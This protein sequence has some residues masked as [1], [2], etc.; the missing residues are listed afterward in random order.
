M[1]TKILN[2]LRRLKKNEG[3]TLIEIVIV[4]TII[5]IL[6]ALIMPNIMDSRKKANVQ[7]TKVAI[8]KIQ[9]ALLNYSLDENRFPTTEEGLEAL[10]QAGL[11]KEKDLRDPWGNPYQ[12]ASPG[13]H[14]NDFDI[15][16]YGADGKEGGEGFNAD[17]TNWE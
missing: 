16:S 17:I 8:N 1:R 3:M 15:Y 9:T 13:E 11:L 12:Y 7:I 6:G 10:V 2:I 5:A 4:V 14:N